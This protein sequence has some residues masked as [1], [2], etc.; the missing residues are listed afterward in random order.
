MSDR[1]EIDRRR[2]SRNIVVLLLL[3]GFVVLIYAITIVK[4]SIKP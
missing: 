1:K 4:M 3:V 2:K